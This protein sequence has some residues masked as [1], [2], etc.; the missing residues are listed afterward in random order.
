MFFPNYF[1]WKSFNLWRS[2]LMTLYHK[3]KTLNGFW[4]RWEL[5]PK[6]LIQPLETLSVELTETHKEIG[7]IRAYAHVTH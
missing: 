2:L 3:T 1:F 7:L 6:F 5:N 4:C